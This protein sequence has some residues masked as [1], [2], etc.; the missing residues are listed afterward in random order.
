MFFAN[1]ER[2]GV[3]IGFSETMKGRSLA[4]TPPPE[5]FLVPFWVHLSYGRAVHGRSPAR[6]G[7]WAGAGVRAS[8]LAFCVSE[9][10]D[11][12]CQA[13]QSPINHP[14]ALCPEGTIFAWQQCHIPKLI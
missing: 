9:R 11:W 5:T 12:H 8:D 10:V 4:L 6:P 2:R 7:K 1:F 14:Y 3:M 13:R